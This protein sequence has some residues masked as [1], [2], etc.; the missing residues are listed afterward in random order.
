MPQTESRCWRVG[1]L[2][3]ATGL[4]VRT[5]HHYDRIGLLTP[6]ERTG[7]GYRLY[8][9]DEV[10]RLYQIVALRRLGLS[11]GD[12]ARV[13]LSEDA[14]ARSTIERHLGALEREIE[15]QE[16]LRYRLRRL[17][18][19]VSRAET[20]DPNE[21]VDILEVM[22]L[23]E[24][25]YTPEQL[26][27]LEERRKEFGDEGIRK[28]EQEWADLIAAVEKEYAAETDPSDPRVQELAHKWQSLIE[29]FTGGDPEIRASL[30]K[31]YETEGPEKASRG[32]VKPEL[33]DYVAR[34]MGSGK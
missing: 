33:M 25:Y 1:E 17:L 19:A 20:T 27:Q 2:A 7:S 26:A 30:Q 31:M 18:D 8:G 12:V 16:Q 24:N 10:R 5:L 4:T 9:A 15:Q 23:H 21:Y 6:R 3:S 22:S 11:L 29:M 14:D 28:V 13:L 32:M 34:A